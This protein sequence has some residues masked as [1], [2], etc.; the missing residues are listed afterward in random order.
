[1]EKYVSGS[2]KGRENFMAFALEKDLLKYLRDNNNSTKFVMLTGNDD[3]NLEK[4]VKRRNR[5]FIE[6]TLQI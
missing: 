4:E 3:Y 1:M 6:K 5:V 2:G